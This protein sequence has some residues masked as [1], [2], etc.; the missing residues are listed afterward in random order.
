MACEPIAM[1]RA[2]HKSESPTIR[3]DREGSHIRTDAFLK[4]PVIAELAMIANGQCRLKRGISDE[5]E[6]AYFGDANILD[7]WLV[8]GDG[9]A[10]PK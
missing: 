1:S 7:A 9:S 4:T 2:R 6:M 5:N 8:I 10:E 3:L